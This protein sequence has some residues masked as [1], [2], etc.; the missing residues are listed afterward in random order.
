MD[1]HVGVI[2]R[3]IGKLGDREEFGFLDGEVGD[4][5]GLGDGK[6]GITATSLLLPVVF[7]V[8]GFICAAAGFTLGGMG[9]PLLSLL[10]LL[11][12]LVLSALSL[13]SSLSLLLPSSPLTTSYSESRTAVGGERNTLEDA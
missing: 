11:A 6:G 9:V 2:L 8:A 10:A 13:S 12:L 5:W 4:C 7:L 1:W 3:T